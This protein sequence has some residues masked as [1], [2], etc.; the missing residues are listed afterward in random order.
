M[1]KKNAPY[2]LLFL[3][4]TMKILISGSRTATDNDY[5]QL[6]KTLDAYQPTHIVHGGAKGFDTLAQRYA[7]DN[8][9]PV[10]VIRPDYEKHAA[11]LAPLMRNH[12][13]VDVADGVVCFYACAAPDRTNGTAHTAKLAEKHGKLLKEVWR[14]GPG[15]QPQ[16]S[17]F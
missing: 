5:D 9:L 15:E 16:M 6:K 14:Q 11:K 8:N 7:D 17:L 3:S 2:Q 4:C 13:L 1:H 10:T 12:K